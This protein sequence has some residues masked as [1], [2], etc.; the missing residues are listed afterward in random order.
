M[1]N[2]KN[3]F[4]GPQAFQIEDKD[5]FFGRENEIYELVS[6]IFAHPVILLY[7]QSGTGKTSLLSAGVIPE[8]RKEEFNV[9]PIIRESLLDKKL[10]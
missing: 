10:L 9:L 7:G 3:P 1:K 6:L 5:R 4:I 2:N 8:I